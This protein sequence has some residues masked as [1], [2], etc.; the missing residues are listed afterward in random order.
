[1]SVLL[2]Y[3]MSQ[4]A[5][6]EKNRSRLLQ[7]PSTAS[8]HGLRPGTAPLQRPASVAIMR[9]EMLAASQRLLA[10]SPP[11]A[12]RPREQS[13][14]AQPLVFTEAEL[15]P[16]DA[17][18]QQRLLF[19]D[20][21]ESPHNAAASAYLTH[22]YQKAVDEWTTALTGE[23]DAARL[24]HV[25]RHRAVAFMQL[26]RLAE[27]QQDLHKM[28]T[29]QPH[30]FDAL[31]LQADLLDRQAAQPHAIL[32]AYSQALRA[33]PDSARTLHKFALVSERV[34]GRVLA[35]RQG[36]PT[37]L[38][39]VPSSAQPAAA[40]DDDEHGRGSSAGAAK[41]A[42]AAFASSTLPLSVYLAAATAGVARPV[43]CITLRP[44][45]GNLDLALG[46]LASESWGAADLL[47]ACPIWS[48]DGRV[49]IAALAAAESAQALQSPSAIGA[50]FAQLSAAP[51]RPA[52]PRL[53]LV[54]Y[55]RHADLLVTVTVTAHEHAPGSAGAR[56]EILSNSAARADGIA[57]ALLLEQPPSFR[58]PADYDVACYGWLAADASA[59]RRFCSSLGAAN[60]RW[61]FNLARAKAIESARAL[62]EVSS[63]S[64]L[65]RAGGRRPLALSSDAARELSRWLDSRGLA[66]HASALAVQGCTLSEPLGLSDEELITIGITDD[67]ERQRIADLHACEVQL[68]ALKSKVDRHEN[69]LEQLGLQLAA[70]KQQAERDAHDAAESKRALREAQSDLVRERDDAAAMRKRGQQLDVQIATDD[71]NKRDLHKRVSSFLSDA[72]SLVTSTEGLKDTL[73]TSFYENRKRIELQT[74]ECI[75]RYTGKSP[76]DPAFALPFEVKALQRALPLRHPSAT[77]TRPSSF[78][79]KIQ[80]E[81][82]SQSSDLADVRVGG[83]GDDGGGGAKLA[84]GGALDA[85][86]RPG[87]ACG[88]LS[89]SPSNAGL[90]ST[91][92][93]RDADSRRGSA[94]SA[95]S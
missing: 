55:E 24:C 85:S 28:L 90:K 93:F 6:K 25:L 71:R 14:T 21:S 80:L 89:R 84:T 79:G 91:P 59:S 9:A 33:Q 3:T 30:A 8:T 61:E 64:S 18:M 26:G 27:A 37:S 76:H 32:G 15:E 46:A 47:T 49:T 4:P 74:A 67:T 5:T 39:A 43:Y 54:K 10:R 7:R 2:R 92:K 44:R 23:E 94:T 58:A 63:E 78:A 88:G 68:R 87:S 35:Q 82:P 42:I 1:M 95:R 70:A 51:S 75:A 29:L 38:R 62:S 57:R 83:G 45:R 22:D 20:T 50:A 69:R 77:Q 13:F 12:R 36:W 73:R 19:G 56:I 72:D 53:Q 34:D 66:H 31:V 81:R 60:E 65:L 17:L 48:D 41:A 16:I 86:T 11:G 40:L 52:L